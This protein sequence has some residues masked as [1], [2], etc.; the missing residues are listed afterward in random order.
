MVDVVF[1]FD[2]GVGD[3]WSVEEGE[4]A[5]HEL[6]EFGFRWAGVVVG[7]DKGADSIRVL[8]PDV[9]AEEDGGGVGGVGEVVGGI[10]A[11]SEG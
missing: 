9:A 2:G 4:V 3:V 10:D 6:E 11:G 7:V 5:E 8:R 1:S